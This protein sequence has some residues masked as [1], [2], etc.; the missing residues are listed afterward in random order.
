MTKHMSLRA[1]APQEFI[2][3]SLEAHATRSCVAVGASVRGSK[4][5]RGRFGLRRDQLLRVSAL[6]VEPAR[7]PELLKLLAR[8]QRISSLAGIARM[9]AMQVNNG[10]VPGCHGRRV[11][12]STNHPI[13]E[14]APPAAS[15]A[16]PPS[17]APRPICAGAFA[18]AATLPPALP[19]RSPSR[20]R[21]V[22]PYGN[23]RSAL[24]QAVGAPA[25]LQATQPMPVPHFCAAWPEKARWVPSLAWRALSGLRQANQA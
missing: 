4:H 24:W 7:G 19:A 12:N 3:T 10:L 8:R 13:A 11:P 21:C 22:Q 16:P 18:L 1:L 25:T 2:L 15:N 6:H 5:P 20:H 9:R 23:T 17:P 14:I